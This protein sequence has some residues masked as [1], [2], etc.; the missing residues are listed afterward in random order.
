MVER[1]VDPKKKLDVFPIF[2]GNIEFRNISIEK[3][4]W[5]KKITKITFK[6]EFRNTITV[7]LDGSGFF[8]SGINDFLYEILK[9]SDILQDKKFRLEIMLKEIE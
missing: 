7:I 8:K 2:I 5:I 3:D 9:D 4:I 1:L 6:D